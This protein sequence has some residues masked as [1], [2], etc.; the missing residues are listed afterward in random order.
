VITNWRLTAIGILSAC[1]LGGCSLFHRGPT[2]QERFTTALAQGNS[3]E[4]G[5]I[6]QNMTPD[7]KEAFAVSNGAQPDRDMEEAARK[8]AEQQSQSR[9]ATSAPDDDDDGRSGKTV[10]DF[11]HGP[12]GPS[13]SVADDNGQSGRTLEDYIPYMKGRT[14]KDQDQPADAAPDN[15]QPA[16][17][18]EEIR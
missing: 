9:D 3:M 5:E 14:E 8:E 15:L 1:A 13:S 2:A 7:E 17:P 16:Q 11:F 10:A 18:S 4:A 12:G 6:W